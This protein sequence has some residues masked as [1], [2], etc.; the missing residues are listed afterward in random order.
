MPD[1][2]YTMEA[3]HKQVPP[4]P[5]LAFSHGS[6]DKYQQENISIPL[7][8]NIPQISRPSSASA[9]ISTPPPNPTETDGLIQ[10]AGPGKDAGS[11][12]TYDF[13]VI[14]IHR[15]NG[16]P[17]NTWTYQKTD[18]NVFWLQEL[19]PKALPGARI[20]TYG[21]DSRTFFSPSTGDISIYA[22]GLLDYVNLERRSKAVC[23]STL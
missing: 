9:S 18:G 12:D 5:Q 1:L 23:S 16:N 3:K 22:K 10:L 2:V 17:F 21:Y 11:T 4:K 6:R 14:A 20:F 7:P 13:D 8:S 19:L 15:L